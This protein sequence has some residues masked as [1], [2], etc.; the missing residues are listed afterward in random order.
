MKTLAVS[1]TTK[2]LS[3]SDTFLAIRSESEYELGL[4]RLSALV[5]EVGDNLEDPRYQ[6]I[7]TLSALID[8]YEMTLSAQRPRRPQPRV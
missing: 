6:L 1:R 4:G 5:D 3:S 7:E 8:A 2:G